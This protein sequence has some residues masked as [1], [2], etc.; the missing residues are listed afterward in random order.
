MR[1]QKQSTGVQEIKKIEDGYAPACPMINGHVTIAYEQQKFAK[2]H[3]TVLKITYLVARQSRLGCKRITYGNESSLSISS[4]NEGYHCR[5]SDR[6]YYRKERNFS[7][8]KAVFKRSPAE[9]WISQDNPES[10][11][12][13]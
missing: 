6:S 11:Y 10:I 7:P 13:E 8:P 9:T 4:N 12:L 1:P 2:Y 5:T 3:T